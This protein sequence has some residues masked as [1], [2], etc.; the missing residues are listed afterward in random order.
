MCL[1][2]KLRIK[3]YFH[4]IQLKI[5]IKIMILATLW[6]EHFACDVFVTF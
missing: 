1:N 6:R 4:Y 5:K 2:G 3:S